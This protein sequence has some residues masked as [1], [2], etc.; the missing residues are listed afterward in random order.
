M[1]LTKTFSQHQFDTALESWSFLGVEGKTPMLTSLFGDV[2]LAAKDGCWQL[3][4]LEGTLTR[5]WDTYQQM[6]AELATEAGEERYLLA[7]LAFVAA[8]R[9]I[10]PGEDEIYDFMPPPILGGQLSVENLSAQDFAM[11]VNIAGQIH[12]QVRDVPPGTAITGFRVE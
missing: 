6:L 1:Q 10:L 11:T 5:R 7:S 4:I 2:F 9:G 3:D 8:A 12:R